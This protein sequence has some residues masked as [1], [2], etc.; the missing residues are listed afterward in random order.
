MIAP[1]TASDAT[2]FT[3][4]RGVTTATLTTILLKKGLRNVWVRGAFPL[5]PG[6]P[7]IVGR[8]FTCA[9]CP[10]AKT[11]PRPRRGP[12][13]CRRARP[14]RPCPTAAW[15]S[16]TRWLSG[17]PAS[18]GD[19]LC[20]R[21]AQRGAARHEAWCATSPACSAPGWAV[22]GGGDRGA[23]FGRRPHVR[24]LAAAD[25][26]WR[27]GRVPRRPDC[28]GPGRRG[29]HSRGARRRRRRCRRRAGARALR[30]AGS[31]TR[32][33]AA[34]APPGLYPANEETK[35]RYEAWKAARTT[36]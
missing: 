12:R 2:L 21:M 9:S 5:A 29:G 32:C 6:T 19:I 15:P 28:R 14:S 11:S 18:W 33:G 27:R 8:A 3:A 36:T 4:L 35:A 17:T 22:W 24:R 26:L 16:W 34:S 20:G 10:R 7:R 30:R 1:V 25:R 23:A 31:S 13:R